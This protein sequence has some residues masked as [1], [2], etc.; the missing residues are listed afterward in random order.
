M[1]SISFTL[2]LLRDALGKTIPVGEVTQIARH[3]LMLRPE[4][5]C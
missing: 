1:L 3:D 2:S 4:L 5:E